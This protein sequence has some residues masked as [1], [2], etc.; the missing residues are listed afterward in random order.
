MKKVLVINGSPK[1]NGNVAKMLSVLSEHISDAKI[2]RIDVNDLKIRPCTGCMQCR[3]TGIC[4]LPEDDAHMIA[5]EIKNCDALIAGTP[6]YW[7]N[8]SGQMKIMFDRIV[9]AMMGETARGIPKPLHKG[10]KAILVTACTTIWPFN[11]LCRQTTKAIGALKE[12]LGYSGFKIVGKVVIPGTK[13]GK[14]Y[15]TGTGRRAIKSAEK[16]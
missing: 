3:T 1:K 11:F 6:V 10:K 8:M 7:G 16:I 4:V 13:N 2:I 15:T 14:G 5:R 12:I 9:P